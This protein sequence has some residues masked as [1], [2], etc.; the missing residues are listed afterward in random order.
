MRAAWAVLVLAAS[1]ACAQKPAVA[2]AYSFSSMKYLEDADDMV[3]WDVSM[4]SSAQGVDAVLYCGA[5]DVQGPVRV[6]FAAMTGKQV[7]RPENSVCGTT[8]TLEFRAGA[9]LITADGS[10]PDRVPRH[11]NFLDQEKFR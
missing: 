11:T 4:I 2:R 6:H 1:M 3:G 10:S 9:L 7:V 5:T 8:L